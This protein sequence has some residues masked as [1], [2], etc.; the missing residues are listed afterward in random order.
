[1][2]NRMASPGFCVVR[3]YYHDERG[4]VR[5]TSRLGQID[6]LMSYDRMIS[7]AHC[8]HQIIDHRSEI[9]DGNLRSSIATARTVEVVMSAL[10]L[11][12][13]IINLGIAL[14]AGVYE[15]RIVVPQWLKRSSEGR[16]QW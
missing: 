13:F 10:L 12:L 11:S 9:I 5:S 16:T 1:M 4:G 7:F 3:L 15:S 6:D 2:M 8:G 14:G